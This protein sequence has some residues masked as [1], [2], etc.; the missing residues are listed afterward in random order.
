MD[1]QRRDVHASGAAIHAIHQSDA[2]TEKDTGIHRCQDR[3]FR[4]GQPGGC[5]AEQRDEQR[6]DDGAEHR[7]H[8]ERLAQTQ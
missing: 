8:E 2:H 1:D 3:V 4:K 7:L 6:I 5:P